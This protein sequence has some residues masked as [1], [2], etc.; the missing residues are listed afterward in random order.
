MR[1]GQVPHH[2]FLAL[3]FLPHPQVSLLPLGLCIFCFL[4]LELSAPSIPIAG[5]FSVFSW[6][7]NSPSSESSSLLAHP[8]QHPLIPLCLFWL[9]FFTTWVFSLATILCIYS[10][11]HCWCHKNIS[12]RTTTFVLI[13]L[14]TVFPE[15]T[16]I[17]GT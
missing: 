1:S 15:P 14:T 12:E 17:P 9:H 11:A 3:P 7:V 13:L 16:T 8:K 6:L 10:I 5:N 2:F 4:D